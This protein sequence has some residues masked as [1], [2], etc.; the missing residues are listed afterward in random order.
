MRLLHTTQMCFKEFFDSEIPPYAILSH[1]WGT[2]E[3]SYQDF[4]TGKKRDGAG[5][6][7]ILS[8][9]KYV[10]VD[11]TMYSDNRLLWGRLDW[12]WIDTCC[13]D[14]S[15]S[16]EL[17]EAINSM[18]RWY[19]NAVVCYAY[20]SDVPNNNEEDCMMKMFESSD[21]FRR[22][23]TLQELLAPIRVVFLNQAWMSI[24][25]R[26]SLVHRISTA[27][28]IST[29]ILTGFCG[30]RQNSIS[31]AEKFS[32]MARRATSRAED[33]AYCLL[34]LFDINMPLLYGEGSKAFR[35][36]QLEILRS[37]NDESMFV[38][39]ILKGSEPLDQS[40]GGFG[41]LSKQTADFTHHH[42]HHHKSDQ[43]SW[44][45]W[46]L[47]R[48][49]YTVTNQGLEFRVPK[50][51]ASKSEFLLPLNYRCS[52]P[53]Q[54]DKIKGLYAILIRKVRSGQQFQGFEGWERVIVRPPMVPPEWL[55]TTVH[56]TYDLES[57]PLI[58]QGLYIVPE[59]ELWTREQLARMESEVIYIEI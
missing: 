24:G 42:Y 53:G 31:A 33:Q 9:C 14:K 43:F 29:N 19:A 39:D 55:S 27:S 25:D 17:S 58:S 38:W 6:A 35:R 13:I 37:S 36:L 56:V 21:W 44:R 48:P 52:R 28:G 26:S 18:Y 23:W 34:G 47:S 10:A 20:L 12:V 41:L 46:G 3:I 11:A 1:R 30:L 59:S 8:C 7:K 5:F 51:L 54:S 22:G 32:W 49:P 50:Y 57:G 16:A 2:D 40:V 45:V 4:L 15:S